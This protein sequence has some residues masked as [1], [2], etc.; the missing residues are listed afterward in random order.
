VSNL[1][2]QVAIVTVLGVAL[3]ALLLALAAAM[4]SQEFPIEADPRLILTTGG[5][6]LALA[7]LA[8][9]ASVRRVA[10]IDPATATTRSTGGGLA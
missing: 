4:S 1:A 2:I 7:L 10:R 5:A 6:V 3:A 9:L 8:S